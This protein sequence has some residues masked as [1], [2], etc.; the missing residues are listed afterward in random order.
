M[1]ITKNDFTPFTSAPL[2]LALMNWAFGFT[3]MNHI[4][5]K[6]YLVPFPE[7]ASILK[8][9]NGPNFILIEWALSSTIH[10][11]WSLHW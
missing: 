2:T 6:L 7:S 4:E 11:L 3:L 5:D 9:D 8:S 10:F 1:N